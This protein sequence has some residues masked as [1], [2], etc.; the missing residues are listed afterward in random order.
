MR[1]T[2]HASIEE[3]VAVR[4]RARANAPRDAARVKPRLIGAAPEAR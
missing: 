3:R 1:V 2:V 4:S